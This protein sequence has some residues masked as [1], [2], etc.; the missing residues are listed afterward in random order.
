VTGKVINLRRTRKQ[1]AHAQTRAEADANA[2][3]HGQSKAT[4]TLRSAQDDLQQRRLNG[5]QIGDE[6]DEPE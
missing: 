1:K 6:S 3:R 5:H 4:R 2:A